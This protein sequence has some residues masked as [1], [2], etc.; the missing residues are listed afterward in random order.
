MLTLWKI[1]SIKSLKIQKD[2][3]YYFQNF[4]MNNSIIL[5]LVTITNLDDILHVSSAQVHGTAVD[6]IKHQLHVVTLKF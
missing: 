4:P 6:I 2:A 3:T 5:N 1:T